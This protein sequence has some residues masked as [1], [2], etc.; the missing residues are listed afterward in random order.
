[1]N[2]LR[3]ALD[4]EA[5]VLPV[6]CLGCGRALAGSSGLCDPCRLS[7]RPIAPPMCGRCGQTLDAWELKADRRSGGQT[8][9]GFSKASGPPVRRS[10]CPPACGFCRR[11]P[12]E[13][14][15]ARSATWFDDGAGR[16]LVHALKYGGWR[17]ASGPM[18]TVIARTLAARLRE[19]DLL[20]PVPLAPLRQRERGYNQAQVLAESLAVLTKVSCE[21]QALARVRE[22]KTQ[23]ALDPRARMSNVA[24]AFSVRGAPYAVRGKRVALVDDV[25]TTG[26]TLAAA[27]QALAAAGAALVGAITFARA[28][29]PGL[30]S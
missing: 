17:V 4:V 21:P 3:L 8:D 29:K 27:A 6:A 13:L 2:A 20:V 9:R 14:S 19:V 16:E 11:W 7:L 24:G 22:T 23:T 12:E 1:M 28:A 26:A 15:W 5:L 30:D 10:A 25:L 18:A